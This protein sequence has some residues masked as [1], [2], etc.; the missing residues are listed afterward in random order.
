M[1]K[2]AMPVDTRGKTVVRPIF[3]KLTIFSTLLVIRLLS[4]RYATIPDCDEVFN[5][6]EPTH[7]LAHNN[8]L[9]TWEYSPGYAL[10]S[11]AYVG[12]HAF[13]CRWISLLPQMSK[14][15]EFYALRCIF[16]ATCAW[17]ETRLYEAISINVS[18][19][20]GMLYLV[21]TMT[22]A[23]MFH[24]ATAYLPSTFAMYT[25][26]LG[27]AAFIDRRHSEERKTVEGVLWFAIG[28][29]LGWPF[30]M[31]MVVPFVMERFLV[32][33]GSNGVG[34]IIGVFIKAALGALGV[35]VAVTAIDTWAY[36]KLEVVS[37]N[38]VMYNVFGGAGKGPNIYGTEPWW[39]YLANLAL[40]FNILLPLALLSVPLLGLFHFVPTSSGRKHRIST[41]ALINLTIPFY[42]WL[43]IFS[44]QPHKEERFMFVV[45]PALCLSSAIAFHAVL[46]IWGAFSTF[47]SATH[48]QLSLQHTLL[49]ISNW[50]VLILPIAAALLISASRILAV[51]TGY[52]ASM[53]M[54][55]P[56][57]IPENAIGNIC[58]GKEWYRF[59]S[60]YFLPDGMRPRFV[61]SAFAGLLPGQFLAGETGKW[62][63]P[64]MWAISEGMN[65]ENQEDIS[66]YVDIA[67]CDYLVDSY[68]PSTSVEPP[69][70]EPNY[71]FDDS[72][73]E[74]VHCE[75]FLD[76]AGTRSFLERALW[77]PGKYQGKT[78]GNYCLLRRKHGAVDGAL[79]PEAGEIS[80]E[81]NEADRDEL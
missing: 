66:K 65:D 33:I 76:A 55:S 74:R 3:S 23:G 6:W 7:Y 26:T 11:W 73:W 5:Y 12:L 49:S 29:L 8:G 48:V 68:L 37:L 34:Q 64:G 15:Y 61:K 1:E 50:G 21:A 14:V 67:T 52:S 72:T 13:L 9:Q 16:A 43:T 27:I 19:K 40:N 79:V 45:Y 36:K 28:G 22:A 20:I 69:E 2:R 80:E 44:L 57:Y 39:F 17:C 4:A 70:L 51:V 38:I 47:I 78:W 25:T 81:E 31:A 59:P 63:R 30:S 54:Y 10:R 46:S 41:L 71:M 35:L 62:D 58:F 53:H 56:K 60:S 32:G 24:A 18:R 77:I 42:L 75:G